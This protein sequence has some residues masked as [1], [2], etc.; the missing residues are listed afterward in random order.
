MLVFDLTTEYGY[1]STLTSK[2]CS[3]TAVPDFQFP[4][5]MVSSVAMNESKTSIGHTLSF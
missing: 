4:V 3:G 2:E 5:H 1:P